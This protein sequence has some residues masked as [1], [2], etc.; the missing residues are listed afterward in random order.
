MVP[1]KGVYLSILKLHWIL[2]VANL[3]AHN[4]LWLWYYMASKFAM[5]KMERSFEIGK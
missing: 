1:L 2:A 3:L 4:N 5:A